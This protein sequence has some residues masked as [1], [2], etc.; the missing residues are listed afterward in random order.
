MNEPLRTAYTQSHNVYIEGGDQAFRYGAGLAYNKTQGVMKNSDRDVI[1]GNITLSY[2]VDNFNFTNQTTISH[3]GS[4]QE[5]VAFSAFAKMNP[6]YE[7]YTEDGQVPKYV[8][9]D[10][11]VGGETIWNPLWDFRQGSYRKGDIMSI[12]DNFQ[13]EWRAPVSC[14]CE[15]T[16]SIRLRR[17]PTRH[18][19]R[20]MKLLRT[21]WNPESAVRITTPTRQT[22]VIAAASMPPTADTGASTP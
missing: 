9:K 20:P 14:V 16:S 19:F 1:N 6:F 22:L 2:R 15:V 8:Y 13:F 10:T 18:T 11:S 12:T 5:T 7:K 3:T 4:S 21:D 17:Q